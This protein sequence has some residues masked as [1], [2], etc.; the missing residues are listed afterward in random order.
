MG[1]VKLEIFVR[2][3][4]VKVDTE[5]RWELEIWEQGSAN[6][7]AQSEK[8]GKSRTDPAGLAELVG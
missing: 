4:K 3:P 1:H 6:E 7:R 8:N 5:E 2:C